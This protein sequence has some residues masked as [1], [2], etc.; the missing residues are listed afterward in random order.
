MPNAY[1]LVRS[2]SLRPGPEL[3]RYISEVDATLEQYGATILV[4]NFP[5]E[6][7]S[8][9]WA[10]FITLLQFPSL[11]D[12]RRWYHSE[13]YQAIRDLRTSSSVATD[14][15]VE[16]VVEGHRS[17]DLLALFDAPGGSESES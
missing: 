4:Q 13:E 6:V 2:D 15:L 14:V 16:G 1:V 5:A 10:G 17:R 9:D 3:I 7:P 11:D 8:G 12:A